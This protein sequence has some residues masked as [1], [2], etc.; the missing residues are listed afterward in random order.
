MTRQGDGCAPG[1]PGVIFS[2]APVPVPAAPAALDALDA[3]DA[4]DAPDEAAAATAR[5][6]AAALGVPVAGS[7]AEP[8]SETDVSFLAAGEYHENWL[9]RAPAGP[10]VLRINRG[11][12]AGSQLGLA[13]QI[14][15]EYRVLH[16]LA[17]CGATP[18]PLAL[19]PA[20]VRPD[21]EAPDVEAPDEQSP[22]KQSPD[23]QS[24]DGTSSA[25]ALPGGALLMQWLPGRP[26]DYRT[27]A[28]HAARVFA[29]VH[30]APVPPSVELPPPGPAPHVL[31]RGV[32]AA[33]PDPVW[34]IAAESSVLLARHA[35][36]PLAPRMAHA[37][38][39][40]LAYRD[41]VARLAGDTRQLFADEAPVIANTEVNSG[42]FLV[43]GG[44]EAGVPGV[45]AAPCGAW[46]VDWEKAV[47]TTRYQDLGHFLS[48]TTTLWKTGFTFDAASRAAFLEAYRAALGDAGQPAP[49]AGEC[50]AKTDVMVRAVLLRGLSWCL[51]AWHE[52]AGG[53]RAL[54][55]ADTFRTIE[56]YLGNIAWFLR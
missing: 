19:A 45:P 29:A 34:A 14:S 4:P 33:Q 41:R 5:A 11:G 12:A 55:H 50:A 42:N 22:H 24:P 51:M 18:R 31:P 25:G 23:R 54:A 20:V 47:V 1:A 8:I 30:E 37:R 7:V 52:Y 32:L 3:L 44:D 2:P 16:A 26:L 15:Y 56:R 38:D 49:G 28:H 40:L 43:P 36:H 46:L 10:V 13:D 21:T 35:G 27:D 53:G 6:W 9:V 48:P 17:R 39:A